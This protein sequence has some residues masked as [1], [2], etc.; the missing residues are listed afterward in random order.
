MMA[1]R[2]VVERL[3]LHEHVLLAR[4]AKSLHTSSLT[5]DMI[6][7]R[8]ALLCPVPGAPK[9]YRIRHELYQAA[10]K[11][12]WI[13]THVGPRAAPLS[14]TSPALQ[15]TKSPSWQ[16]AVPIIPAYHVQ[17]QPEWGP[18]PTGRVIRLL[19]ASTRK[20]P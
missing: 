19:V 2:L 9:R 11:I 16:S 6:P 18:R 17:A 15:A 1:K 3:C 5:Q 10:A 20:T 8:D 4:A 12:T 13:K 7:V 14:T